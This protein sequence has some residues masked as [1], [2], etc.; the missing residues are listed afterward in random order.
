M[1]L[2]SRMYNLWKGFISIF[3]GKVEEKNPEIAFEN[4]INSMTEK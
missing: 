4:A 2:F 1:S 3:V